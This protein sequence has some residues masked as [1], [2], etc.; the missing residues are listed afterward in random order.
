MAHELTIFPAENRN[1]RPANDAPSKRRRAKETRVSQEGALTRPE[2]G[3]I[4]A[5]KGDA[6]ETP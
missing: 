2:S 4:L 1:L 6:G 3:Q 5:Q